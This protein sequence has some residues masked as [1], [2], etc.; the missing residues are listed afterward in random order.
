LHRSHRRDFRQDEGVEDQ[1]VHG[2]SIYASPADGHGTRQLSDGQISEWPKDYA[3]GNHPVWELC[4]AYYQR[5]KKPVVIGGLMLVFGYVWALVRQVER[6]VSPELVA[7]HR[8]EQMQR[9]KRFFA[10]NS[11]P[12][13]TVEDPPLSV[14]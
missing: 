1:D 2:Q 8:R 6:P 9:L 11:V 10:G 7:F 4:R 3:I 5:T 13:K 12:E 14:R